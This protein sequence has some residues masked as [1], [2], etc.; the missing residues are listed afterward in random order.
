MHRIPEFAES[1]LV[2]LKHMPHVE[3]QGMGCVPVLQLLEVGVV[4]ES[5]DVQR[6]LAVLRCARL[7][8]LS[9]NEQVRGKAF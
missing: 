6:G 5:H 1:V 9:G 2:S 4:C 3:V 8:W 7:A